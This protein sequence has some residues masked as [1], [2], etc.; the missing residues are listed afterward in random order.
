MRLPRLQPPDSCKTWTPRWSPVTTSTS[1]PAGAGWSA[2]SSR[3]P[4][5]V[6]V[7]LTFWGTSWRLSSKVSTHTHT[8]THARTKMHTRTH[9]HTHT[10][11]H[12][13]EN[14]HTHTR[15]LP[16]TPGA[17]VFGKKRRTARVGRALSVGDVRASI[18]ADDV[19]WSLLLLFF[20]PCARRCSGDGEQGGQGGHPQ[21]QDSVQLL[22]E[23]E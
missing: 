21:G 22:H 2:T 18:T 12:T 5:L 23:R 8:H 3:R 7:Y 9:A 11:T 10:H 17:C 4:A 6:T 14:A 1:T 16:H 15:T 20:S 13:H 19:C